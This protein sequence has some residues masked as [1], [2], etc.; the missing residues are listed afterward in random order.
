MPNSN[1]YASLLIDLDF[2]ETQVEVLTSRFNELL[3]QNNLLQ[4]QLKNLQAENEALRSQISSPETE[5]MNST[6]ESSTDNKEVI[7]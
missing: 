6:E 1:K 2:L 5:F 3:K 7:P 4:D